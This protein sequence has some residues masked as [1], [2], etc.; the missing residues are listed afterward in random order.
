[1]FYDGNSEPHF[2]KNIKDVWKQEYT[3]R[4]GVAVFDI[5]CFLFKTDRTRST[6]FCIL[7]K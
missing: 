7:L 4:R 1:M 5:K 2:L 6:S 3:I